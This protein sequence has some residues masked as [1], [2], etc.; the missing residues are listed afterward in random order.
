MHIN[1]NIF[2]RTIKQAVIPCFLLV[3]IVSIF[4][5]KIWQRK[6]IFCNENSLGFS[7]NCFN[8]SRRKQYSPTPDYPG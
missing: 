2:K 6:N 8:V 4:Y 1:E 3:F 5:G 7:H